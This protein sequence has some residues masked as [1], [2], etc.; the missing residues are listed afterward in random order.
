MPFLILTT[1]SL[2]A[3]IAWGQD[4]GWP[5]VVN[6]RNTQIVVYQP[7]PDSLDGVTLQSRVAISVKRPEDKAPLFGALWVIATL[8]VDRDRDLARV[9]SIKVDRT[10]FAGVPD[11]DV[12]SLVQ[13]LEADVP[14]WDLSISLTRLK[15]S[16][17]PAQGGPDADYRND[18]PRI[19]VADSPAILLL[20]DGEPRRQEAGSGGLQKVVN[21]AL[22][23]IFDPK[24]KQYWFYGSSVWFST[25]DLLHGSW[26]STDKAPSNVADLV[27]DTET[28]DSA[29]N[30]AGK[31]APPSQLRAARIIVATEPTELIVTQGAPR[32]S[33]LVG[34]DIL[35]VTNTDS[36]IFMETATQ[37]HFIVMS[38]RWF[39]GLQSKA[40]GVLS[41]PRICRRHLRTFRKIRPRPTASPSFPART[42]RKMR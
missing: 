17:Q 7:Q 9:V 18:P 21:T 1:V 15:A 34:G 10:R 42:A 5:R 37:R 2:T 27:K 38:G 8:S 29:Q 30:D 31:A 19:I 24:S 6:D 35:Y 3:G 40:H 4:A 41:L 12:Q 13:F 33:P 32:Y 22:P 20:L 25:N 39:A 26:S 14:L 23:A 36:D 28:L 16:L 11:S